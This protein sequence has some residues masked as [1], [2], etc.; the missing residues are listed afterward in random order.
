MNIELKALVVFDDHVDRSL[1]E[2][3]LTSGPQLDVADYVE[4]A[5]P[6]SDRVGGGD[7]VIVACATFNASVSEYIAAARRHHPGR[8]IV[9]ISTTA[10]N[11]H[12]AQAMGAGA[13][14][15]LTLPP[16]ADLAMVQQMSEEVAF[17]VEKALARKRGVQTP[18]GQKLGRMICV[19]GLK[20]G[21]GKTLTAANLSVSLANAGHSVA[22][23]DLDLQFG[24]IGLTLGMSPE[25]TVYDLVRSGGSIDTGKLSDF[26]AVH[27]SGVRALLAPARPDQAGVVTPGFLKDVYPL[28]REMHDFVV[29]DTPPSFTPEVIGAVDASSEACMVSMLDSPSLKNTKLGLETLALMEY[30]G[31]IRLVLNRADSNVGISEDDVVS[32][33]G[34]PPDVLVPSERNIV[35]SVNQ[36]EPI[37][38]LQRRSDAARAF[39]ALAEL[40]VGDGQDAGDESGRRRRLLR[41]GR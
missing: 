23:V 38:L 16:Q 13:D 24:D 6:E 2:T 1:V 35:R 33:V 36:G 22:I 21:S 29:V 26:L 25:R 4:L 30:P 37:T 15:I 17:S 9:L 3:L 28:L 41:R 12:V 31:R 40:Y 7:V 20:G 18:T 32:I 19:L 39:Q 14:D 11:G 10:L 34:R 5:G 8:P 27:P